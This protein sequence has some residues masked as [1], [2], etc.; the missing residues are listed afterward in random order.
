MSENPSPSYFEQFR[1]P[2]LPFVYWIKDKQKAELVVRDVS[3][4]GTFGLET[5]F[6]VLPSKLFLIDPNINWLLTEIRQDDFDNAKMNLDNIW[7]H[8]DFSE[9]PSQ[10]KM[11][12]L[13]IASTKSMV[14]Q[15]QT[16]VFRNLD[17]RFMEIP[18]IRDLKKGQR[19]VYIVDGP[20]FSELDSYRRYLTVR[21]YNPLDLKVRSSS[22]P[23]LCVDSFK[24]Y[25][26]HVLDLVKE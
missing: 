20:H 16:M 23:T 13:N 7:E 21:G 19:L 9:L 6:G 2:R 5:G 11:F 25:P 24:H 14:A 15:A 26:T 12:A 10:F 8:D 3:S 18:N 17:Y 4:A 1:D 22:L